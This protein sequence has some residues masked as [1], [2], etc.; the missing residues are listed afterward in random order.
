MASSDADGIVKLW[1]VRTVTERLTIDM[2]PFPANHVTFDPSST[3]LVVPSDSH[4]VKVYVAHCYDLQYFPCV[5]AFIVVVVNYGVVI[6]S[7]FRYNIVENRFVTDFRGHDD[8]VNA[9]IFDPYS[10]Y[11]VSASSDG[12]MHIW[13]PR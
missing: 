12:I 1:D 6:Y 11:L 13:A 8:A 4:I 5:V 3:F 7:Y 2:G 9:V 10:R